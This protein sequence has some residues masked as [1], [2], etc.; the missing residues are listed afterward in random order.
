MIQA[1]NR[2]TKLK[3]LCDYYRFRLRFWLHKH[4]TTYIRE[5]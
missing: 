3:A 5:K 2:P 4:P 1:H